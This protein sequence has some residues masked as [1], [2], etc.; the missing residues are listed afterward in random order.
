MIDQYH[1]EEVQPLY[2][3]GDARQALICFDGYP[4]RQP[5]TIGRETTCTLYDAGHILGSA[6][7]IIRS[8]ENGRTFTICYTG[9]IGRFNKPII[10]N[11]TLDFEEKDRQVD[12]LITESTYCDRIHEPVMDLK[13]HLRQVI[14]DTYNRGGTVLIPSF[15][16]GRTQ[17]LLY[18]LHELRNENQIP[19]LPVFLDSPL[20]INITRVFGEHP[21]VYDKE[22]HQDFLQ[23]GINPFSFKGVHFVRSVEE[24]MALNRNDSP[25]IVIAA[26]G[27][28]EAG[29][30]LHHLRYK[31]HNPKTTILIVGYMAQNTLGRRILEYGREYENSGRKGP[32]PRVRILNKEYPLNAR[33]VSLGGFSAHGDKKEM[34]RFLKESNLNIKKIAVVHGEEKQSLAFGQYLKEEGYNVTVPKAGEIIHFKP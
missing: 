22:A 34:R 6:I 20:G 16:F 19:S 25:H 3:S 10:K 26:S 1:L 8:R 4:Y 24:S 33:V 9:D 2:S 17:E 32:P 15:A 28:C 21:E 13:P 18:L 23:K 7:T 27:M 31:C 5:L 12:L 11:P 29:R 14:V 30:I